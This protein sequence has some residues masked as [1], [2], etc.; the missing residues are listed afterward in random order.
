MCPFNYRTFRKTTYWWN[1]QLNLFTEQYQ[2]PKTSIRIF[3]F[4]MLLVWQQQ[5]NVMKV[6]YKYTMTSSDQ[7][8]WIFS[9]LSGRIYSVKLILLKLKVQ[10][11]HC[12]CNYFVNYPAHVVRSSLIRLVLFHPLNTFLPDIKSPQIHCH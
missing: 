12:F 4:D 5:K 6:T 9:R 2:S 8:L 11:T 10:Q 1:H 3:E 7:T